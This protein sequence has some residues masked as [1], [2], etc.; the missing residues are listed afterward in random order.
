[1]AARPAG[2]DAYAGCTANKILEVI[3]ASGGW[4]TGRLESTAAMLAQ[5]CLR[6]LSLLLPS[7]PPACR[8]VGRTL[9]AGSGTPALQADMVGC[10]SMNVV[11]LIYPFVR[12]SWRSA[13]RQ[14][15]K[16]CSERHSHHDQC[17][18]DE[19]ALSQHDLMKGVCVPCFERSAYQG[20]NES[21]AG[22]RESR[23][24]PTSCA[25]PQRRDPCNC[26][27]K[28]AAAR[29][30]L[31]VASCAL[32]CLRWHD[33]CSIDPQALQTHDERAG[34]RVGACKGCLRDDGMHRVLAMGT[35]PGSLAAICSKQTVLGR[36]VGLQPDRV[37]RNQDLCQGCC[38][39]QACCIT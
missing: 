15:T 31:E 34:Q 11:L 38:R 1:M 8:Q 17:V 23:S 25:P 35:P 32:A 39:L 36:R 29:L 30:L 21:G 18:D 4:K 26:S 3:L 37:Q 24:G 12:R 28:A 20:H 10:L 13:R 6:K 22:P 19:T 2:R 33:K 7:E 16:A 9:F 5:S 14:L 27:R